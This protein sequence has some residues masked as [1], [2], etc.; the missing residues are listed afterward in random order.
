MREV[1]SLSALSLSAHFFFWN[2]LR[3]QIEGC[4]Y[5]KV[6]LAI[7]NLMQETKTDKLEGMPAAIWSRIFCL[8]IR[9]QR[10]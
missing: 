10:I 2:H 8:P 3:A 4:L 5:L 7:Q 9:H 6:T 1:L